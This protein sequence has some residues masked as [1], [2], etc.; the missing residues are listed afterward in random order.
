MREQPHTAVTKNEGIVGVRVRLEARTQ[1][2]G[3]MALCDGE[4][5]GEA[6]GVDESCVGVEVADGH[7]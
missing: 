4:V 3:E 5:A 1:E 6:V 7:A 2:R